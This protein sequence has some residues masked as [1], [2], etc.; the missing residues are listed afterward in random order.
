[1]VDKAELQTWWDVRTEEEQTLLREAKDVYP[2]P[3]AAVAL[4]INTNC[5]GVPVG[6]R[7]VE[8]P[9]PGYSLGMP[10]ELSDFIAALDGDEA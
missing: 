10:N 3:P 8:S 6:A 7:W 2:M 9:D 4:L 5:P 1:M